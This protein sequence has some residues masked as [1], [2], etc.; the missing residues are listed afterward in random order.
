MNRYTAEHR[1]E[2]FP[3]EWCVIDENIGPVGCAI[4]F[5]LYQDTAIKITRALNKYE[6]EETDDE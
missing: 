6:N 4:A 1:G 2:E 3:N 5:G